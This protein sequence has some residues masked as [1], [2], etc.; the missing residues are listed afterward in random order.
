MQVTHSSGRKVTIRRRDPE[1][2]ERIQE[3]IEAYPYCFVPT[4]KLTDTY[5]LVRTEPGYEGVYGTELTKVYFRNEY[6]RREWVRAN[7]T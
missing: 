1:T 7:H 2:L 6:D 5:G 3:V 4:A